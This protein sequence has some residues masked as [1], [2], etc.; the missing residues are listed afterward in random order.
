MDRDDWFPMAI[1]AGV[2]LVIG[3][4]CGAAVLTGGAKYAAITECSVKTM[5]PAE[6]AAAMK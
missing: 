5:K 1:V 6:C 3:L 4:V 2:V